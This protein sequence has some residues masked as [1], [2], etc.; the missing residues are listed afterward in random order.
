MDQRIKNLPAVPQ[1][2]AEEQDL[3]QHSGLKDPALLQLQ[4]RSQLQLGF[5]PWPGDFHMPWVQPKIKIEIK[6]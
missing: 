2:T 3:T 5:S 6:K 4:Q 1:V